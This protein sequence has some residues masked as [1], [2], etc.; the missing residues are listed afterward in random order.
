[1]RTPHNPF[2]DEYV[3]FIVDNDPERGLKACAAEVIEAGNDLEAMEIAGAAFALLDDAFYS[4]GLVHGD[5]T[6][7]CGS[8]SPKLSPRMRVS[9]V[10]GLN[11]RKICDLARS[12][13]DSY[14]ILLRS[15]KFQKVSYYADAAMIDMRRSAPDCI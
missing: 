3:F 11:A 9:N 10:M 12:L 4:Y 14:P 15:S 7:A 8:H 5:R 6:I 2:Q 1:M 13:G